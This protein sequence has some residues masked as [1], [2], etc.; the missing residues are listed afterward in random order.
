MIWLRMYVGCTMLKAPDVPLALTARVA[1]PVLTTL[2]WVWVPE[3]QTSVLPAVPN[4]ELG[5]SMLMLVTVIP[6]AA[7]PL[8][9]AVAVLYWPPNDPPSGPRGTVPSRRAAYDPPMSSLPA[10]TR[11]RRSGRLNV[12]DPSPA[13]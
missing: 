3:A 12:V 5:P 2:A 10:T 6:P 13:P 8:T 7:V 4:V 9:L 11:S 1:L